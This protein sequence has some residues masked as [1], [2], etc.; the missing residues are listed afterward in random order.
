M[1]DSDVTIP[2]RL[3]FADS[4]SFHDVVVRIPASVLS[5]YERIID[6]VREDPEVTASIFVDTRR[7]VAAYR[8]E[9]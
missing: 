4:G 6:A 9:A 1:S 3:V 7:L 8:D 2:V 5:R